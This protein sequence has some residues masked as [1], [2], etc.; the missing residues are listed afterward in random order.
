MDQKMGP[1]H[2]TA[3]TH[4]AVHGKMDVVKY[5]QTLDEDF[6]TGWRGVKAMIQTTD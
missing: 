5:L 3:L 4:A 1:Q 6:H 2:W